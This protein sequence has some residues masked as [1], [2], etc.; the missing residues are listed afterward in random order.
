MSF[1]AFGFDQRISAGIRSLG[2]EIP[3]PIQIQ[4]IPPV[5]KGGDVMGLAQTGS[6]KTA[7]FALPILQRILDDNVS[8]KGPARVLVLAPTREL[9]LQ[10]HETFV[11]LGRQTGIRSA[12]VFG[13]VGV[14]PQVKALRNATVVVACPGRLIDLINRGEADMSQI[15]TL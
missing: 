8:R 1:E 6:G 11:E 15:D 12:A 2:Y 13:G 10:I 3:T 5:L 4:A 9:A 7:A 14:M